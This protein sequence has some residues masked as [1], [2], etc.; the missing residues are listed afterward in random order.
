M[1][2]QAD[3]SRPGRWAQG[4]RA[5]G[6]TGAGLAVPMLAV[7]ALAMTGMMAGVA[8]AGA[9]A[10]ATS[11]HSGAAAAPPAVRAWG[12]D[13]DGELGNG[14]D[15]TGLGPVKVKL[16]AGV[17]VTSVRAGCDHSVALT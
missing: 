10:A 5:R 14:T 13:D 1:R 9:A 6:W 15:G 11:A 8:S 4:P 12:T 3:G 7:S 17:T 2:R 16:P